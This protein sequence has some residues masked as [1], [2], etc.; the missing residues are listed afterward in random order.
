MY[1]IHIFFSTKF[2]H[3]YKFIL[4]SS[5]QN[6]DPFLLCYRHTSKIHL[7]KLNSYSFRIYK[8]SFI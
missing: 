4:P 7:Y 1:V 5:I 2:K 6:P 3:I 8:F